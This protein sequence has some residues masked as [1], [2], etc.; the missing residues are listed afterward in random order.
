MPTFNQI[1]KRYKRKRKKHKTRVSS[2]KGAPILK[3]TCQKV[4]F[5]KPKKPNSANRRI[6]K[7]VLS[8]DSFII[9]A[10][11]G[12][13]NILTDH[14]NI[15]IRGGR[16]R[17]LPGVHYKIIKGALDFSWKELFDRSKSRSKYGRPKYAPRLNNG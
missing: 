2:L 4:V 16:V 5:V 1:I 11:P 7:V 8:N 12:Q 3:G 17:D 9:A 14:A 13:G 6:A 10:V 15:L